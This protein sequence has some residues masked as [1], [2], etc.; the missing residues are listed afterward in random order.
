L[1]SAQ[2]IA[3]IYT[4]HDSIATGNSLSLVSTETNAS[5]IA[6]TIKALK[7]LIGTLTGNVVGNA[8]TATTLKDARNFTIGNTTKSFNGSANVSW[9]SSEIGYRHIWS[10]SVKGKT[11]SRLC[12]VK[13]GY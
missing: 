11:W 7:G 4:D 5:F 13:Y 2:K 10:A 3:L 8:S 6:P 9:S 1:S 12:L